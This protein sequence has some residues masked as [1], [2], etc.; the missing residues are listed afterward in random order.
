MFQLRSLASILVHPESKFHAGLKYQIIRSQ[1]RDF[2]L[3]LKAKIQH[4][5]AVK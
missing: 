3:T 2:F 5:K 1:A 4:S